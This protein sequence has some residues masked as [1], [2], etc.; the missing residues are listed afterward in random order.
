MLSVK[1]IAPRM[2]IFARA[3]NLADSRI[4]LKEGVLTAM[5][6][7]IESSFFLGHAILL[8]MGVSEKSIERLLD[9]MR[10]NQYDMLDLQISDKQ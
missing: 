2:K 4:L 6:E 8:H 3:R 5:P 10:A 7:T 9:E 1:S